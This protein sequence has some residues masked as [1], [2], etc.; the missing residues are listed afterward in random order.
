MDIIM[1]MNAK[2]GI[3]VVRYTALLAVNWAGLAMATP[4]ERPSIHPYLE[5]GQVLTGDLRAD[6]VLTYS[7]LSIGA[8]ASVRRART[9]VQ[10]NYRYDRHIS[11]GKDLGE[12][13]AHYGMGRARTELIV[14]HLFLDGGILATRTRQSFNGAALGDGVLDDTNSSQLFSAYV[15]PEARTQLGILDIGARYRLSYTRARNNWLAVPSLENDFLAPFGSSV[16][17][18][19]EAHIGVRP[20]PLPFGWSLS[21][22]IGQDRQGLLAGRF[23]QR[24]MRFDLTL[25][26]NDSLALIGGVGQQWLRSSQKEALRDAQGGAVQDQQGRIQADPLKPRRLVYDFEGLYWDV[27]LQWRP[28]SRTALDVRM[29]RRFGARSSTASFNWQAH[30]D[31]ALTF[32]IYD[33]AETLGQELARGL[34]GLPA[35]YWAGGYG[36]LLAGLGCGFG[37]HGGGTCLN[38]SFAGLNGTAYRSR[39]GELVWSQRRGRLGLGFG[40]GYHR[41]DFLGLAAVVPDQQSGFANIGL[42]YQ[43]SYQ[44]EVRGD[45]VVSIYDE[46]GTFGTPLVAE[47]MTVSL[48]HGFSRRLSGRASLGITSSQGD[49]HDLLL[50]SARAGLRY[51]F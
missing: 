28:S 33:E 49:G 35:S 38:D 15:A 23:T 7:T 17:Q 30:P 46:I 22:G 11:W 18:S 21:G 20:G 48:S 9:E 27:G 43:A 36:S 14:D 3:I 47:T 13:D 6:D 50:G 42:T 26:I 29:G 24:Q 32:S 40:L 41:R 8:D 2:R 34:D 1:A 45:L 31:A 12:H 51:Q 19:A 25:P 4:T 16:A 44:T 5:V 39:G 10:L 37:D